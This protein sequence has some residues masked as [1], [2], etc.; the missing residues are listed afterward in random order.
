MTR[1]FHKPRRAG[2]A[3]AATMA[4]VRS[5][6]SDEISGLDVAADLLAVNRNTVWRWTD[7]SP[8]NADRSIPLRH[9]RS[10][11]GASGNMVLTE[12]LAAEAGA[13]VLQFPDGPPEAAGGAHASKL[14]AQQA[15]A[16]EG[17]ARAIEDHKI[18]PKE[19]GEMI[20]LLDGE[21]RAAVAFRGFLQKVRDGE[22]AG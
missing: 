12:F 7:P 10:L 16:W 17:Y 21:L 13:V 15:R 3:K 2:G 9:I 11:Q 18:T 4:L 1:A 8:E 6:G 19:A 14:A 20:D 5:F 22:D